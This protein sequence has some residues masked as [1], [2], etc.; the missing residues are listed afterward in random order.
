MAVRSGAGTGVIVS[1]V[2]FIILTI[3][4][5]ALSIAFYTGRN[6]AEQASDESGK[7]LAKY[8]TAQQQGTDRF[9]TIEQQAAATRQSVA[10]WLDERYDDLAR[11]VVPGDPKSL[12][13]I[14]ADL[15]SLGLDEGESVRDALAGAQRD[16]RA[17]QSEIDG[18]NARLRDR[19]QELSEARAR[20][21]RQRE[22]HRAQLDKVS[23]EIVTYREQGEEYRRQLTDTIDRMNEAVESMR[24]DY[25]QRIADLEDELD[26]RGQEIVL[27]R[28]RLDEYQSILDEIRIKAQNP[29]MLVD[30]EIID[31][32]AANDQ[33][34][35]N[36]GRNDRIVLGMTFEVYDDASS[37]RLDRTG[38]LPRG[39]ASLQVTKVGPTTST[40]KVTRSISGRPVVRNDVVA[41]AVYDPNRRFKFLVHG[42]FD[43]DGD[44]RPTEQEAEHLR[45]VVIEWGGQVILGEELPGDLDFLVIGEQPPLPRPLQV[46][47]TPAQIEIWAKQRAARQKYDELAQLAREA[48]IPILNANR[49]FIL[50]GRAD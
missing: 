12:E 38:L 20:L 27:A 6:K 1:L 43:V 31:V 17:R 39:K 14:K 37:I 46:D 35:I 18:L 42:K 10:G 28:A 49:F 44:G 21:D 26:S 24:D 25:E 4:M 41:N 3:S 9:R 32:D 30:A 7:A 23:Q 50:I 16:L 2:V 34:F 47:A 45:S 29:A 22:D 11:F 8:V 19:D 48:Q 13:E 40:C 36:R 33:V 15:G 5:L